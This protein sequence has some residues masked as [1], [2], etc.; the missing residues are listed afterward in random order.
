VANDKDDRFFQVN[1]TKAEI[2]KRSIRVCP[3][4]V[5]GGDLGY[6][7]NFHSHVIDHAGMEDFGLK[8]QVIAFLA[9]MGDSKELGYLVLAIVEDL[10]KVAEGCG[11]DPAHQPGYRGFD[12]DSHIPETYRVIVAEFFKQV[13]EQLPRMAGVRC[14]PDAGRD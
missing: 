14:S 3:G 7:G 10:F 1:G 11:F 4:E 2:D 9:G 6:V 13:R 12:L 8:V 5:Q